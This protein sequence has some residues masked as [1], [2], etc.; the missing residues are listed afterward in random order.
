[1]KISQKNAKLLKLLITGETIPSSQMNKALRD[2]LLADGV[3]DQK[4]TGRTKKTLFFKNPDNISTYLKNQFG[5][6]DIDKYIDLLENEN[7]TKADAVEISS[8]SKIKSTRS[9][10]GF[11]IQV[12]EDITVTMMEKDIILSP[13]K[14]LFTFVSDWKS[15]MPNPDVIIIG[16]ENGETFSNIEDYSHLFDTN[17]QYLFVSRYPQ[18]TDLREWLLMIPNR[19]IH[20]GDF[21]IAGIAIYYN[22]IKK[23]LDDRAE[24]FV[25]GAIEKLIEEYGNRELFDK[26]IHLLDSA[27]MIE[28]ENVIKLLSL[29]FNMKKGLEQE[30]FSK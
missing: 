2:T 26:Q 8:N 11:P 13:Q 22:E 25:P 5:I 19:Y 17:K 4:V 7:S 14:G 1:M 23:Y 21:D 27:K 16:V 10:S 3:L 29:I 12:L 18:S 15:F 20:F 6:S 9:F 24:F 30:L 28:E